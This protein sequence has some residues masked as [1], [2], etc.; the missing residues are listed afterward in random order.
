[1][2]A[3]SAI[4]GSVIVAQYKPVPPA[5]PAQQTKYERALNLCFSEHFS[6]R[7]RYWR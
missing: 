6:L 3:A 5:A 2:L 1:M 4:L 7:E